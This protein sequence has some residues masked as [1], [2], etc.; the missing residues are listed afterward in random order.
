MADYYGDA[1]QHRPKW[2]AIRRALD[3]VIRNTHDASNSGIQFLYQH[4]S[5]KSRRKPLDIDGATLFSDESVSATS[6]AYPY[7]R[8]MPDGLTQQKASAKL[9][10]DSEFPMVGS[11]L[12]AAGPAEE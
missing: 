11:E 1:V 3:I 4:R 5:E 6:Y 2:R 9:N 8:L 10:R 7:L 12:V